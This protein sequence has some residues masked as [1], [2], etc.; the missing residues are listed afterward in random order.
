MPLKAPGIAGA[1]FTLTRRTAAAH[2]AWPPGS[3]AARRCRPS[4]E[5]ARH[6][7]RQRLGAGQ[8]EDVIGVPRSRPRT[9]ASPMRNRAAHDRPGEVNSPVCSSR[10]GTRRWVSA[11]RSRKPRRRFGDSARTSNAAASA[12]SRVRRA[13]DPRGRSPRGAGYGGC[14][15]SSDTP[16]AVQAA[17]PRTR[18]A[19]RVA[20]AERPREVPSV[21]PGEVDLHLVGRPAQRGD[22][23]E[24]LAGEV[25][26]SSIRPAARR[27]EASRP[28]PRLP[29]RRRGIAAGCP[30]AIRARRAGSHAGRWAESRRRPRLGCRDEWARIP[31]GSGPWPGEEPVQR[32]EVPAVDDDVVGKGCPLAIHL[33]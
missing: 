18:R 4:A 19:S 24:V 15:Q 26:S 2:P 27:P 3:H 33:M 5:R 25:A 30:R 13:R 21:E 16:R 22:G 7:A 29:Q 31:A 23:R 32:V 1:R 6:A 11:S 12:A 20:A 8:E 28:G 10:T 14:H 9:S 17:A